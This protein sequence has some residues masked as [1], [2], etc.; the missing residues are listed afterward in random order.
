MSFA[1]IALSLRDYFLSSHFEKHFGEKT[2]I[3]ALS[4]KNQ[5]DQQALEELNHTN[6]R[7]A[8]EPHP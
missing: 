6:R 2:M 7:A 3:L 1:Y 5:T 8:V 4:R